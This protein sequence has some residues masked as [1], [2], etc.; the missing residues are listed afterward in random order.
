MLKGLLLLSELPGLPGDVEILESS[1]EK[2]V[3]ED[4]YDEQENYLVHLNESLSGS[5]KRTLCCEEAE[6]LVERQNEK[7]KRFYEDFGPFPPA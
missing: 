7:Y 1:V 3:Y 5:S 2:T 6:V 4:E